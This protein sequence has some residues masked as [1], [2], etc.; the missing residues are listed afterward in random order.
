MK[1]EYLWLEALKDDARVG[2]YDLLKKPCNIVG[3]D[4]RCEM[5]FKHLSL[6]R[7]HAAFVHHK[8]EGVGLFLIDL[9]SR[10][11]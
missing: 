10:Q 3:R 6:S 9:G 11:S 1:P 7:Q 2:N 4:T 5:P 8:G